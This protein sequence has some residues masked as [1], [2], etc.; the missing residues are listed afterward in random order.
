M[1]L[2]SNQALRQAIWRHWKIHSANHLFRIMEQRNDEKILGWTIHLIPHRE[3]F[4]D[5]GPIKAGRTKIAHYFPKAVNWFF[6]FFLWTDIYQNRSHQCCF[7]LLS[8]KV[9]YTSLWFVKHVGFVLANMLNWFALL[10]S[11]L[12]NSINNKQCKTN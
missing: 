4:I 8:L 9:P 11:P 2:C 10:F 1:S 7:L 5:N 6:F 12:A 3:T